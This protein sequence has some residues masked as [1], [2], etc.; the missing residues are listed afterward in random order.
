ME[1]NLGR[2]S[3]DDMAVLPYSG[4]ERLALLCQT[5]ITLAESMRGTRR[6]LLDLTTKH[7][8]PNATL[9]F[10]EPDETE[11]LEFDL[12]HEVVVANQAWEQ[13]IAALAPI[14]EEVGVWP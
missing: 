7:G 6:T 9:Q 2:I 3:K 13:V 8:L 10:T 11:I 1:A 12:N 14:Q 5:L 4:D